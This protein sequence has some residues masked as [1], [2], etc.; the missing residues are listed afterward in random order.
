MN[1]IIN[2]LKD[3]TMTARLI[4]PVMGLTEI[5]LIVKRHYKWLVELVGADLTLEV[6]EEDF[7][8][9]PQS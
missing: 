2:N 9:D 1:Y 8:L 3:T 7:V 6:R 5:R 4:F